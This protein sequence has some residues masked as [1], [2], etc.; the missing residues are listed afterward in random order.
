[1]GNSSGRFVWYELATTDLEASKAFYASVVGWGTREASIPGS[2]YCQ[3]TAGNTPVAGLFK[4]PADA[5]RNGAVPQ[6][7]GF[8]GVNDVDV[9]TGRVKQLGGTVHVPPTNVPN[10]TR[11]SVIADPQMA[12]LALVKKPE[13]SNERSAR[14][15]APGHVGWHELLASDLERVFA[16]YSELLGWQ[17]TEAPAGLEGIYQLFSAGTETIG[18]LFTRPET[19]PSS[20][21]LY[22]FNVGDIVAAA[23]RVKDSGGQILYGP[24]AVPGGTRVAHCTDP[25]GVIFALI[26]RPVRIVVGCY[27]ARPSDRPNRG[28]PG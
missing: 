21:W 4:L 19:S 26:D 7:L 9:A 10:I 8:V 11:F 2:A 17:P 18:G 23:K 25:Q 1:M 22:Y 5:R 14:P 6:W 12:A 16:F 13:R 3:F 24:V 27:S 15:D 20:H 28:Q